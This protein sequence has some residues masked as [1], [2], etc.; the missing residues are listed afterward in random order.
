MAVPVRDA[1]A[2]TLRGTLLMLRISLVGLAAMSAALIA[3][4]VIDI[5]GDY[6]LAH[7]AYDDVAHGSRVVFVTAVLA[8]ALAIG[9]RLV[10]DLL[11]RRCDSRAS[12]LRLVRNSLGRVV[13][14][15]AQSAAV[16][17]VVLAGMEFFD[18]LSAHAVPAGINEL[19]GGSYMLGLSAACAAAALTGWLVHRVVRFTSERE[20][21]IVALIRFLQMPALFACDDVHVGKRVCG[22]ISIRR[23][24]LLSSRGTKRG[25]PLP[26]PG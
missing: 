15:I 12:L 17:V 13:P 4:V 7:D 19:F 14:F 5:V 21:E 8:L 16:C 6:V 18:C 9:S 3:H 20:P 25:P 24:L 11:D 26:I 23:A 1:G 10:F 22:P 2:W